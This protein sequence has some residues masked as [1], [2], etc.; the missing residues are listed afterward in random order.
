MRALWSVNLKDWVTATSTGGKKALDVNIANTVTT[1][2]GS[3]SYKERRFHD[4]ALTTIPASASNPVELN[5]L[6]AASPTDV[7]N[8]AT[9]MG[10]NWNG[11]SAIEILAGAT[12]GAAVAI[13]AFGAGQTR[14]VGVTLA[15]GDKIWVRAI[16][17]ATITAG[18]LTVVLEG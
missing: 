11:G 8:T 7:A 12:A 9:Q 2:A 5:V 15:A 1:A 16:Q 14:A 13:A 3:L 6:G 10:V 18:E 4:A 17:N